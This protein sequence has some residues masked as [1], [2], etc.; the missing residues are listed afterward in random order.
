VFKRLSS[1]RFIYQLT[2]LG[3]A[4]TSSSYC[5][6]SA[7]ATYTKAS[8]EQEW[9][10]NHAGE[11]GGVIGNAR[12]GPGR[13]WVTVGLWLASWEPLSLAYP[14]GPPRPLRQ[15]ELGLFVG[16]PRSP[17]FT[18]HSGYYS[19]Y[20]SSQQPKAVRRVCR[21]SSPACFLPSLFA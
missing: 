2:D 21:C 3:L 15:R 4:S 5:L 16:P 11:V 1:W 12:G 17:V 13:L 18:C 7:E 9:W 14:A 10:A 6:V 19:A 8:V 20:S